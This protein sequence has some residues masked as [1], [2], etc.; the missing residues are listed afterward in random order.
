MEKLK[1]RNGQLEAENSMLKSKLTEMRNFTKRMV[2]ITA[3]MDLLLSD[4][5]KEIEKLKQEI[6]SSV[7]VNDI[8]FSANST[9]STKVNGSN[10]KTGGS[11]LEADITNLSPPSS[12]ATVNDNE[13]ADFTMELDEFVAE[14]TQVK[15]EPVDQMKSTEINELQIEKSEDG[16]FKCPYTDICNFTAPKRSRVI[17]HIRSHTGEKPFR[18]QYCE[19]RF[20]QSGHCRRH[21]LSHPESNGKLC[22]FCWGR[23]KPDKIDDHTKKCSKRK[24]RPLKRKR[25]LVG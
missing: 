25:S 10:S 1:A 22:E 4:K 11:V 9:N 24:G 3:E 6:K 7:P 2:E 12:D 19:I 23:F 5:A 8:E 15:E 16:R 14:L 18:C 20:A 17:Y 21:E 13:I